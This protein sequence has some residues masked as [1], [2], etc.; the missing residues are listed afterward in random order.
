MAGT[1]FS[2][3]NITST[4][5]LVVALGTGGAYAAGQITSSDIKN[6]TITGKDVKANALTGAAIKESSLKPSCAKTMA[7]VAGMCIEKTARVSS[8]GTSLG[9]D[10]VVCLAKGWRIPSI[11]ELVAGVVSGKIVHNDQVAE[12]STSFYGP[13]LNNVAIYAA[14]LST[15]N[16]VT[17]LDGN[18]PP[19][20]HA[21][22]CAV[23]AR[24]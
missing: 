23:E 17:T 1:R 13:T 18:T 16:V 8:T 5:A 7:Y 3:A 14:G 24:G 10:L 11:E 21:F 2:Y 22:R 12:Y 4:L 9:E 20:P 6:H 15:A 19:S